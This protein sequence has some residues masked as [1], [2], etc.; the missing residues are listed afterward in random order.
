[1][2]IDFKTYVPIL[3]WR[4]GEYQALH[5][6]SDRAKEAI[7]P[8]LLI[9]PI[10]YDFEEERMKRTV[11]E[12]I[13]PFPKKYDDKWGKGKALIDIHESLDLA[14]VEGGRFALEHVFDDLRMRECAAIPVAR[15][16]R[17]KAYTNQVQRIAEVD[18]RGVCLRVG[19]TELMRPDFNS[20]LKDICMELGVELSEIDLVLDLGEPENF[21]PID[22]FAKLILGRMRS[23]NGLDDF[24]S[25]VVAGMSLKLSEVKKPGGE[26]PR[27]EW[28]LYKAMLKVL[29]ETRVPSYGDYTVETPKFS[30]MDMRL[31]NPAGKIVYTCDDTWLIPKGGSFRRDNSQMTGHCAEIIKS[32]HY[33]DISFS[34]GDKRINDTG[35]GTASCGNQTTWKQ[36]A[37]N[38]HIEKVVDQLANYPVA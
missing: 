7:I 4:M 26:V 34:F 24:R 36:V 14:S 32:G 28:A 13:L 11:D 33:L 22:V 29:G 37:V 17:T 3:K 23:I 27:L 2:K 5:R 31:L 8:L 1:M 35:N 30:E 10:E 20:R 38:H 19:L 6:L 12:H 15:M 16:S 18:E 9:P 21:E 25:L